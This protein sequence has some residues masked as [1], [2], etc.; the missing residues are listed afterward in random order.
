MSIL[1]NQKLVSFLK[2]SGGE[3]H[4]KLPD[5]EVAEN[6]TILANLNSSDDVMSLLLVV[7]AV[8]RI[9]PSTKIALTIPYFP[10]ARQDR[11]CNEGEAL[12]VKVMA[13]LIN[14]LNCASLTI[15]DPHSDVT[16]ALLNNCRVVSVADIISKSFLAKE[17]NTKN[18]LLVSPDAGAEKKVRMVAKK[19]AS[20]GILVEVLCATKSRDTMTGNITSTTIHGDVKGKNIMIVDDICDGGATFIELAK[21]L[22]EQGAG[23]IYLYVS[24]GIFSKGLA[25]LGEHF[26]HVYCYHTLLQSESV[27]ESFLTVLSGH[28]ELH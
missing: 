25:V 4:I 6:T 10:Y 19:L 11:V 27:N 13:D 3:C 28:D 16:P 9:N 26:K 8:R 12:S 14:S 22:K 20:A 18:L 17:I 5:F 24:H 15:Y 21:L 23:D 7:D 1:V 2:F